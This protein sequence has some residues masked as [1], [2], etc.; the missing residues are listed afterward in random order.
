MMM[1]LLS[2]GVVA[3]ALGLVLLAGGL[4]YTVHETEQ[5]I[6]TQFQ[7]PVGEP[8][9]T[10]GLKVKT[11]FI[12]EVHRLDRRVLDWDG[13][14]TEMPTKDKTYLVVDAFGAWRISDPR[15]FFQRMRDE[16][17]AQSRLDDIIGSEIRTVVAGH[18]LIE[19]VRS[20]RERRPPAEDPSADGLIRQVVW[21]EIRV[22]RGALEQLVFE[23]AAPKL[24]VFGIELLHVQFTRINYNDTVQLSIYQ[25]MISE[26]QQIAERFRSEG[27]GEAARI[28]GNREREL[29]T[30]ESEAYRKVETIRG[31]ADARATEIY[32]RAFNQSPEAAA[33]YGFLKTLETWQKTMDSG[34]TV[35]LTTDSDLFRLLKGIE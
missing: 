9:T 10:A 18:E 27:Q 30:I 34:T 7:R 15:I 23:A 5:V 33:F 2:L 3:L 13:R 21:P 11:P 1:K 14:P 31:E 17:S 4:F 26:R 25:R 24:A 29:R 28:L 32:A 19:I 16:R 6:I 22:G 12:Q 20:D 35:L 8:V